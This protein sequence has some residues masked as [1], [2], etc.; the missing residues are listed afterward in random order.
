MT[1]QNDEQ[2]N[3][4][5]SAVKVK[6]GVS[7]IS[8]VGVIAIKD[9]PKGT[10]LFMATFP[11][12]FTIPY[13]SIYK[14]FPE[15]RELILERW[16]NIVN[17]DSSFFWP[18]TFLQGYANHSDKNNYDSIL[19]LTIE[20]IMEGEEIFEDYRDIKNYEKVFPW[21]ALL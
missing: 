4:L 10:K 1:N 20:D 14:L 3:F 5:N 11:Q 15:I 9:I 13:G 21:L 12:K 18:D 16:P 2:I 7:K 19:D 6:I 17:G 8:G